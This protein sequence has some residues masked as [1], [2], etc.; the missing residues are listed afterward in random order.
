MLPSA[1]IVARLTSVNVDWWAK[2]TLAEIYN[3]QLSITRGVQKV[4][5]FDML[6]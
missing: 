3:N 4:L 6:D 5:Q 1:M 2:C